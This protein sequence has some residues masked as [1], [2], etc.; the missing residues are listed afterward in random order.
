MVGSAAPCA[1]PSFMFHTVLE[2]RLGCSNLCVKDFS[3]SYVMSGGVHLR[4]VTDDLACLSYR[5]Q[6]PTLYFV[7]S[8]KLNIWNIL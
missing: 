4:T 8:L 7:L 2:T 3:F 1:V 6:N 5:E